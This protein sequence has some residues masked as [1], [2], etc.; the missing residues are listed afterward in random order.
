MIHNNDEEIEEEIE[1]EEEAVFQTEDE[2][3]LIGLYGEI[4][5]ESAQQICLSLLT[6]NGG[7][8]LYT[9][10]DDD[11]EE[12]DP[13]DI[14]LFISSGGGAVSD[15]FAIYDLM[16]L[17][18]KNRDIAT[19]G[20]GK[21][22]SAGVPL[23]ATGTLGKRHISPNTRVML[24][25][26]SSNVSGPQ[27]SMRTNFEEL[28]KVEEMMVQLLADNSKLSTEEI[29]EIFSSNTDKYFSAEEALEMGLVD[30][31]I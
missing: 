25:H 27:P 29:Y 22:A 18:K 4:T 3:S 23:L 12:E 20:Y 7:K 10:R 6:C 16:Q 17:V 15:M 13:D 30:K 14:E 31:I 2:S 9:K 26:C 1:N 28:K 5:E 21:V 24:H 8:I 11:E 19:F